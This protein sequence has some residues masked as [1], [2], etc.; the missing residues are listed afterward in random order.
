MPSNRDLIARA[1]EQSVQSWQGPRDRLAP[2]TIDVAVH[3]TREPGSQPRRRIQGTDVVQQIAVLNAAFKGSGFSFRLRSISSYEN[4][5]FFANCDDQDVEFDFKRQHAVNPAR[6]LN[7]YTCNS[8]EYLGWA[9]YPSE[10][11][12]ARFHH[13][14]VV[15]F[16]AFKRK[17]FGYTSF[18]AGDTVVHE[19]GHY[20]GLYHT[21][22]GG[23]SYPNDYIAD[24]PPE[25]I[26]TS[27][28]RGCPQRTDTCPEPGKDSVRNYMNYY[29]DPCSNEFTP[30]QIQFMK[31]VT[32]A[33][34]PSL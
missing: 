15:D 22:E 31:E 4:T 23:C 14:I 25:E 33:F 19:V 11:S 12:E 34:R 3:L 8:Q 30:E 2:K 9:Y 13:G 26:R 10:G 29:D 5:E 27:S 7:I 1:V 16:R 32:A 18:S 20:L 17:K 28:I 21:F 24:T 6:T